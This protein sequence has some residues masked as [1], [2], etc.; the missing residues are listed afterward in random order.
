MTQY[1]VSRDETRHGKD[2]EHHLAKGEN[3]SM[4]LW[5]NEQPSDTA[6]KEPHANDYETL[7]YVIS[8]RAELTVDG[9]TLTL[10]PGD[11]YLVPRGTQHTYRVLE[12]LTAV[13]VVS[14]AQ[15]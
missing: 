15:G 6:D 2:G 1:K 12:T 10:Q 5:H 14:P 3:S 8:G 11:S 7:G 9:E 13:E 4:R